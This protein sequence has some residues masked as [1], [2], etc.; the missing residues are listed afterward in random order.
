M[1][2]RTTVPSTENHHFQPQRIKQVMIEASYLSKP[3]HLHTRKDRYEFGRALRLKCPLAAHAEYSV[4]YQGRSNPIELLIES[5][6][7]RIAR[8]LPIRYGR[9]VAS[10]FAFFRGA[11]L[12]MAGDLAHT[13]STQYA[14][15]SCGD[16]HL[17]NFG[18]FATPERN[19]I[20]DINDFD[21]TYPA[22]WEWDVKR[23]AASF[24]VASLHNGHRLSD[25]VES[26]S[27]AAQS[28]AERL[29]ELAEMKTLDLW[30]SYLD[31]QELIELTKDKKLKSMRKK[32]LAKALSRD[33]LE[34]FVRLATIEG[35]TPRIRDQPPLIYHEVNDDTAEY[36]EAVRKAVEG[37][38]ASLPVERRILF[39]KYELVDVA[40]KVVGVGSVGTACSI[41]LF[42]AA[43]RDP[44]FLQIKEAQESVLQRFSNFIYTQTHGERVVFG[45]RL[46]QAASDLFLGHFVGDSGR[47]YYVRQLRDVK[48]RPL[49]EIFSPAN[50]RGHARNCGWALARAHARSSDPAIIAGYTGKGKVFAEA[51]AK[52]AAAYARQNESDYKKLRKAIKEGLIEVIIE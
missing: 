45:Q 38:R 13:P 35:T 25:A 15:Q 32:V 43:E 31:Y 8:L 19:I 28:Y 10:P 7:G 9:M 20:F 42:F 48:V 16:C 26:A 51:I 11:A 30:Y 12:I 41:A 4:G 3:V 22:T 18:A 24:V 33:S 23:L 46:M 40:T 47:H 39:D 1:A 44:L 50:M 2:R 52:F 14:V 6:K 29:H 37:Y 49:V 17:L 36:Q 27:C 21:E 34:E 5:G